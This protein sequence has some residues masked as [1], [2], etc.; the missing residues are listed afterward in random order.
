MPRRPPGDLTQL[1]TRRTLG[2]PSA[3][4]LAVALLGCATGVD[5]GGAAVAS[6][7]ARE[8]IYVLRSLRE[9]RTAKS[10]WCT[11]ERAGFAPFN[12]EFLIDDRFTM[13]AV[14]VPPGNGRVA[15]AKS[16]K[17]GDLRA[18]FG[19]TAD[20]KV[21]NFYAEA[22]ISGLSMVGKGDC[23]VV[24]RDFPEQGFATFRCYLDLRGLPPAYVGG[25]LTTSS[26]N[27]KALLGSESDPPGYV[28]PSIATIRLWRA[29]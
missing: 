22:Q 7:N 29:R 19:L 15:D 5:P 12:S 28:Q 26:V 16:S 25:L 11:A 27:S 24:R 13:W 17:A 4:L 9:E 14:H 1:S 10:T 2:L 20:P 18:C 6:A 23:L 3:A 8:E 21:I